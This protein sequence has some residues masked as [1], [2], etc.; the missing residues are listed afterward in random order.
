M[1]GKSVLSST[2]VDHMQVVS[3]AKEFSHCTCSNYM[4]NIFKKLLVELNKDVLIIN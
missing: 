3:L 4:Y 1:E 2:V